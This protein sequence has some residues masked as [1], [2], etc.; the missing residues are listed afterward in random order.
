MIKK[1]YFE[2]TNVCNLSCS[3]CPGTKR[4]KG[5]VSLENFE[6]I[7]AKLSGR[8]PYLYLHLM[9]EP[10]AHP[11]LSEILAIAE[12][13]GFKVIITTN[14]TLLAQ[15]GHIL[16]GSGAVYKVSISL[17]SLEANGKNKADV[18]DKYLAECFEFCRDAASKGIISVVRLWNLDG[19]KTVGENSDNPRIL[20]QMRQYFGEK[21]VNTRSGMRIADK[22]FLEYGEKFEWPDPQM[23]PSLP[24][25]DDSKYF[26][27]GLRDQIGILWNGDVV[28]CCLDGEGTIVLG[29]LLDSTLEEILDSDKAKS[30]YNSFAAK[31]A[32][33]PLCRTCGY[34][35]RFTK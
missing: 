31:K 11:Q 1:A 28:P 25:E 20:A 13:L 4:E 7:A 29:N 35:K 2:I 34:A 12:R 26:C 18:M 3:F 23:I 10:T 27:H 8:I 32:P 9:G 15:R 24:E 6:R 14:G 16:L 22:I 17:H 21:W 19:E 33:H 5:F 30:F